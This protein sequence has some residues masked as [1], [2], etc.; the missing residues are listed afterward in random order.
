M[1]GRKIQMSLIQTNT[2]SILHAGV[3]INQYNNKFSK[4]FK[5]Y[6]GEDAV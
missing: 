4:P 6:L 3:A 1:G 5:P 2:K